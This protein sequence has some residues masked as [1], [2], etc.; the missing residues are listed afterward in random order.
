MLVQDAARIAAEKLR[1]DHKINEYPVDVAALAESLDIDVSPVT[2]I[3]DR[4][5]GMIIANAETKTVEILIAED[6]DF[7][8]QRFT[9]AHELGHYE[10][11]KAAKDED[12][13]F[14]E[15]RHPDAY[16]LHEFYADEFAG[17]LLMPEK[18]ICRLYNA[19]KSISAMATFFGVTSSAVRKRITRL[20][21]M[22]S[23]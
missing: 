23:L 3:D 17:N 11:R 15:K 13:S 18:E 22:G 14:V 7:E 6:E 5:S 8:R 21:K 19:D 2:F 4:T 10:E 12:Y 16:N 1:K 20:Q 9:I